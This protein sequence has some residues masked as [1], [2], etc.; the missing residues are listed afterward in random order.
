[1]TGAE[2]QRIDRLSSWY[3]DQQLSFDRRL[4]GYHYQTIRP[5]FR[6]RR[7]LELGPA[8]G[9][10]TRL[11]VADF[12]AVTAVDAAARL[13]QQIAP[14][15][16]LRKVCSLFEQFEP[17]ERFNTIV[18]KGVLEHV[19][20]P[21]ALLRRARQ[22]LAPRGRIIAG[23]PNAN[24]FHRLA[25][26][27]MGLLRNAAQLNERDRSLGHRRVYTRS[28]LLADIRRAG[29]RAVASGGVFFKPLSMQQIESTWTESMMDGFY[30]LGKQFPFNAAELFA[31]C[32]PAR[33]RGAARRRAAR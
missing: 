5:Y 7:A 20:D 15:A 9:Q 17:A 6:G 10:M 3:L 27:H 22:W 18:M 29:L 1:M 12:D 16:N 4:I 31:V 21:V 32:E 28:T 30:E 13:L 14:A 26:V 8:E 2:Q 24:S 25:A 19:A 23:V 11:L 33:G